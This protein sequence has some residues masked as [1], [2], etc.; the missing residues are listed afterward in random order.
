MDCI[1]TGASVETAVS[2]AANND[3]P[4]TYRECSELPLVAALSEQWDRLLQSTACN[5]A[6]NSAAW[7]RQGRLKP[8]VLTPGGEVIAI[9]ICFTG[10]R[11]LCAWSG[12]FLPKA[13]EY[14]R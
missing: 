11:S 12:G 10:P 9:D 14:P 13:E 6:F 2:Y 8:F 1:A 4:V 3:G 7:F 5:R